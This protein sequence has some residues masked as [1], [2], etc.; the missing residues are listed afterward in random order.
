MTIILIAVL[1]FL[2]ALAMIVLFGSTLRA[3]DELDRRMV[4]IVR[5]AVRE[6]APD[7]ASSDEELPQEG[8]GPDEDG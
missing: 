2:I 3:E 5:G 7:A 4:D 6:E 1:F 8:D